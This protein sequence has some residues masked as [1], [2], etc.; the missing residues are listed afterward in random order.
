MDKV[1]LLLAAVVLG[2]IAIYLAYKAK[3]DG[4]RDHKALLGFRALGMLM[5]Y[6]GFAV[7]VGGDASSAYY[8]DPVALLLE[9]IAHVIIM[10]SFFYFYKTALEAALQTKEFWFK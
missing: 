7:H 5:L 10:V 8:G 1:Y 4:F 6:L 3:R 9:S 2:A